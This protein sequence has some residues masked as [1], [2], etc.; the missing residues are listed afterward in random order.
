[1]TFLMLLKSV[2]FALGVFRVSG[3]INCRA[4]SLLGGCVI[5]PISSGKPEC[6]GWW[7]TKVDLCP[8]P[9]VAHAKSR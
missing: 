4:S 8:G 1:M 7:D 5:V 9:N 2:I 6:D 3:Q